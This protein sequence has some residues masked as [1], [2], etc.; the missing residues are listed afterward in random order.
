MV[1]AIVSE[2]VLRVTT[3]QYRLFGHEIG[4][5]PIERMQE[6]DGIRS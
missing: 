5:V 4:A 1:R 3:S 6:C 2:E